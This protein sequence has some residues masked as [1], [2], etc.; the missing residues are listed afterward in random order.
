MGDAGESL[1]TAQTPVGSGALETIFGSLLGDADIYAIFIDNPA[2]FSAKTSGNSTTAD[3]QLFLF[4]SSGMGITHN[5]D[6]PNAAGLQSAI[7][8][9]FVP[10]AGVYYLAVS[11]YNY[12]P[13]SAG[14]AIWANSPFNVERQPDGPGAGS[15]LSS[16]SGTAFSDGAYE[17]NLR[18]ASFVP[19]PG[20]L[21]LL[22]LGGLAATRRRR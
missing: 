12:D 11:N 16:W 20:A 7:T 19:A 9:Q 14:G 4:D 10:G 3:T 5:D 6:D 15:P 13:Q 22:G 2:G 1:G 21:A 8:G 17:I 18:G